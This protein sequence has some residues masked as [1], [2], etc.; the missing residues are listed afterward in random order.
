MSDQLGIR[1][2]RNA[3]TERQIIYGIKKIGFPHPIKA[4][5][6]VH[7]RRQV[8]I[9]RLDIFEIY[10]RNPFENHIP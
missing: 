1:R 4:Q 10:N 9:C 7:L 8:K 3:M 6:T 2:T 5:K